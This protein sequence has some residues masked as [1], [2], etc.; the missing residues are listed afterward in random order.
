MLRISQVIYILVASQ[1]ITK[2]C[3][4]GSKFLLGLIR[5]TSMCEEARSYSQLDLPSLPESFNKGMALCWS[6]S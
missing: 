6:T 5:H 2:M 1:L 4:F 3:A